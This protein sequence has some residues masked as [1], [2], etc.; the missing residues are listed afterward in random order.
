MPV[1]SEDVLQTSAYL[2]G[3]FEWLSSLSRFGIR[4]GLDRTRR[5]LKEFGNPES[6]LKFYHV[7]GTNGKGS[8]CSFLASVLSVNH[9]VGLFTSPAFDGLRGRF[10]IQ[11]N[12][13]AEDEFVNLTWRVREVVETITP[14]DPL[15]EFEVLTVMAILYFAKHHVDAVVWETGLGGRFDSTNVVTPVVAGITNVSY[16]HMEILGDTIRAIAFDK[17]GIIK[18]GVPIVTAA[19]DDAYL[20]IQTVAEAQKAPLYHYRVHFT[21]SP[22]ASVAQEQRMNYR[23]LYSDLFGLSV[24]L[25]GRHQ[26]ENA[27]VALAMY[28]TSCARHDCVRARDEEI[29]RALKSVRWPGR[30]EIMNLEGRPVVLDGAHN[31][32]GARKFSDALM[33]FSLQYGVPVDDWTMVI[34][35]LADKQVRP[36]LESVLPLAGRIIA[37]A[38]QV[39]RAKPASALAKDITGVAGLRSTLTL[40]VMPSIEEAM[41][42]AWKLG[43]PIA[44]WG[45]LYTVDEARKAIQERP[46]D[47]V[48]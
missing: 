5:V 3:A 14:Q 17:A 41:R 37:T 32:E 24:P 18:P 44:C 20:V 22:A 15:T 27:A 19:S 47:F 13:I 23:G 39:P 30:F 45:S 12:P 43:K 38:P 29:L 26:Y 31:P 1:L 9:T 7:A 8:V 4:P 16:D 6:K 25:W 48:K 10:T 36:M 28:E 34:G 33:Q 42:E 11:G 21:S 2:R 40:R 35:V 46:D